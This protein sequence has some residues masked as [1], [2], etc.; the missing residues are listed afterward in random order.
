METEVKELTA[1]EEVLKQLIRENPSASKREIGKK[2]QELGIYEHE[3]S[4]LHV[5]G[6]DSSLDRFKK[7]LDEY[8]HQEIV[9]PA[10]KIHADQLKR[11]EKR[12]KDNDEIL[13]GSAKDWVIS[14]EKLAGE[15][16]NIKVEQRTSVAHLIGLVEDLVTN[17]PD[18]AF[19]DDEDGTE[20]RGEDPGKVET[21][22]SPDDKEDDGQPT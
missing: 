4:A 16:V 14:G 15:Q 11:I 1:K 17:V 18:D 6:P 22:P 10:Y 3:R 9:A 7:A 19:D 13:R 21:P 20:D 5:M 8:A 12:A 2:A